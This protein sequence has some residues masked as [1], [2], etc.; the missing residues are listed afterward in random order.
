M[1]LKDLMLISVVCCSGLVAEAAT[2]DAFETSHSAETS[3]MTPP[4]QGVGSVAN[5]TATALGV[6]RDLF[7][8]KTSG[9]D[10][11]RLR[12]RVNPLGATK[13]RIDADAE[14]LGSVFI[15]WDGVD[16]NPNPFSGI[17]YN[18]LGGVDLTAGA[19]SIELIASFSDIG[20]PIH[21]SV[22]DATA[23]DASAVATATLNLPGGIPP[24]TPTAFMLPFADFTGMTS[25][26]T[27]A[28]AV[29]MELE[30]QG[31]WD[32]NIV[33]VKTVPEPTSL[34]LFG[35]GSLLVGLIR[36]RRS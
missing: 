14:V 31:A 32:V 25:A 10:D 1:S 8:H 33:S 35:A 20:G 34:G 29:L 23:N 22:F 4:P 16:G 27:N 5:P 2:I 21:F 9:A 24:N 17:D 13:L 36:R 3:V 6:E 12:A 18:G 7:V 26:L 19:D 11:E 28:G 15:T 30:N